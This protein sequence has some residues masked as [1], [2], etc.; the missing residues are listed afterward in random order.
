MKRIVSI[1]KW[2]REAA[3]VSKRLLPSAIA[4][5]SEG[6]DCPPDADLDSR[7]KEDRSGDCKH[8]FGQKTTVLKASRYCGNCML[9]ELF[10]EPLRIR[11]ASC[12]LWRCG[13]YLCR[14]P[15]YDC[16]PR[17]ELVR[18]ISGASGTRHLR[19][20]LRPRLQVVG[21]RR[22]SQSCDGG[23]A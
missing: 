17:P 6:P 15:S 10:P 18:V 11:S 20:H 12:E 8:V 19:G 7:L 22:L 4:Y 1:T 14:F 23:S 16:S 5:R 13:S 9:C 21:R 3:S 2:K